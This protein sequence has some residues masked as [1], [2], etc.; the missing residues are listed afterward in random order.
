MLSEVRLLESFATLISTIVSWQPS[1]GLESN[2]VS[3]PLVRLYSVQRHFGPS[4]FV[5]MVVEEG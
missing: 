4:E 5:L 2:I 3:Y 1:T